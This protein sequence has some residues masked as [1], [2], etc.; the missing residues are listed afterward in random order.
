M[1]KSTLNAND[2]SPEQRD[3]ELFWR[4]LSATALKHYQPPFFIFSA[5]PF[6]EALSQLDR[7]LQDVGRPVRHWLSC[8]TQPVRPLLE[9]WRARG[10]GI[11]VVSEFEFRAAMSVGFAPEQ[12]LVNGPAKHSWLPRFATDRLRGLSVNIDSPAEASVLAPLANKLAW[13]VGVRFLTAEESD[14]EGP[15]YPTQFGVSPGELPAVAAVLRRHKIEVMTAHFHLRT[16]VSNPE[17]YRRAIVETRNLCAQVG[18]RPRNLDCG[19]GLPPGFV[20]NHHGQTYDRAFRLSDWATMLREQLGRWEGIEEL[21]LENGRFLSAGAGVLVVRVLDVKE[22]RNMRQLICDGGRTNNALVA[23]WE[24]HPIL[25]LP[26]RRGVSVPTTI[27]GP[28]CMAFDRLA[29]RPFP[30]SIRAGDNLVWLDAG[31]YHISWENHF[32][33]GLARVLWHDERGLSCVREPETFETWW[34]RWR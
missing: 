13:R 31:A 11:E 34:G 21:W 1:S 22:R 26:A 27:T 3:R 5:T 12:I 19:G 10:F 17:V 15:Q 9:W 18:F 4:A 28:T 29:R 8:K 23:T 24:D 7:C 33:H 20:T 6:A 14:M 25:T 32:S 2:P 30:K 16:N